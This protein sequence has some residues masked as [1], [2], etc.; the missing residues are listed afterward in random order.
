MAR[1]K[2][3]ALVFLLALGLGRSPATAQVSPTICT[4]A[5]AKDFG[6]CV[7][8]QPVLTPTG[9][10]DFPGSIA[11]AAGEFSGLKINFL[12]VADLYSGVTARADLSRSGGLLSVGS[13]WSLFSSPF[14]SNEVS[15]L[16][17]RATDALLYWAIEGRLVTSNLSLD[18]VRLVATIDLAGLRSQLKLPQTCRMGGMTYHDTHGTFWGVDIVNDVYFEFGEDGKLQ[19]D[20]EG[21]PI[22]FFSPNRNPFGGGSYGNGITYANVAGANYFDLPVG[23]LTE[24]G[25]RRLM[26][27]HADPGERGGISFRIGDPTGLAV[28]LV[29]PLGSYDFLSGVAYVPNACAPD[30]HMELVLSIALPGSGTPS[31]IFQVSMD[32][33]PAAGVIRLSAEPQANNVLL[34]WTTPNA[35]SK[36]EILRRQLPSTAFVSV[37]TFTQTAQDPREYLDK[38]LGDGVYEYS[39]KLS[40]PAPN[41]A[42]VIPETLRKVVVGQGSIAASG[43]FLSANRTPDVE[44]FGITRIESANRFL[45]AD[46]KTGFAHLFTPALTIEGV[47][48]GPFTTDAATGGRTMGVEWDKESNNLIWVLES[49]GGNFI[50][51]TNLQGDPIGARQPIDVPG[52]I[53]R[54]PRIADVAQ[55]AA[56]KELWAIDRTSML[57]YSIDAAGN[58]TGNSFTEQL[59]APRTP[60]GEFGGGVAVVESDGGKLVLDL[61]AGKTSSGGPHEL[62]RMS[63]TRSGATG[64]KLSVPG[65]ELLAIDLREILQSP[66][67][68]GVVSALEGETRFNYVVGVDT[69]T[70]YKLN[71][72]SG[73]KGKL[74]RRGEVTG[75]NGAPNISDAIAIL[76]F[77]F[78]GGPSLPC[79]DAAD[80]NDDE[81][82]E[83]ADAILL[84]S[85]LFKNGDPPA[86]PFAACGRDFDPGLICAAADCK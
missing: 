26:R 1:R 6:S 13:A 37:K 70:V 17:F 64:S 35:Y 62:V 54:A 20:D 51:R 40:A 75:D 27:V 16:A 31:R 86:N 12:Y 44:P 82:L 14:G 72:E 9:F 57:A 10:V 48:A 21:K 69:M 43:T 7:V 49:S 77:L 55:D 23:E 65:T 59:P 74:F 19:L 73:L 4:C 47:V 15:G 84:F 63:Y 3:S 2:V 42:A 28:P 33:P 79:E 8:V 83:I 76:N 71:M 60:D 18:D 81:K 38:G 80:I 32:A 58:L 5:E 52:N 66:E 56:R 34:G 25:V 85:Y 22:H 45:V 78:K 67:I 24:G 41:A 50:Q 53:R 36:L 11:V 68:G 30:Q 39:V 29:R 46:R 61:V